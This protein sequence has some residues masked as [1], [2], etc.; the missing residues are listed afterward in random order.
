MKHSRRYYS[1]L[2]AIEKLKNY[3]VIEGVDLLKETSTAKF[4]ETIDISVN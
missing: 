1:N 3:D 2:K 4:H